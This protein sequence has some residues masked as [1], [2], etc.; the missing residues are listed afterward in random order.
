ML[1]LSN[2]SAISQ[3]LKI[4]SLEYPKTMISKQAL[5]QQATLYTPRLKLDQLGESILLA[6]WFVKSQ[7]LVLSLYE[8]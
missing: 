8:S 3:I 1:A 4:S 5:A 7:G 2:T 6:W